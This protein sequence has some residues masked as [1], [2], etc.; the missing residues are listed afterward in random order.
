MEFFQNNFSFYKVI[1]LF[2]ILYSLPI[3][4]N[5]QS[6]ERKGKFL[7]NIGPEFRITP[8]YKLNEE[9][10]KSFYTEIDAQNTGIALNLS[11]NYYVSNELSIGFRNSIRY[12]MITAED[13]QADS[14][15]GISGVKNGILLGEAFNDI[16][17]YS[18]EGKAISLDIDV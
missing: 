4:V 2:F 10:T 16:H 8:I 12:D 17:L 9:S 3:I 7:F 15:L 13:I 14:S 11:V 5:S 6:L 18:P 1:V